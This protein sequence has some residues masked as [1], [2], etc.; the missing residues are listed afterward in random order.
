MDR[1]MVGR[2]YA[3]HLTETDLRLL[4]AAAAEADGVG[5]SK[6]G[7]GVRTR[8]CVPSRSLLVVTV[9]RMTR[10]SS[11]VAPPQMPKPNPRTSA[12]SRHRARTG[13]AGQ[14]SAERHPRS[15][16][17]SLF[18]SAPFRVLGIKNGNSPVLGR[19]HKTRLSHFSGW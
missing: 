7:R 14:T 3:S 13:Q 2:E 9:L 1:L 6:P 4:A 18:R 5:Q 10:R 12:Q 15:A 17:E 16:G 8:G 11:S 19:R